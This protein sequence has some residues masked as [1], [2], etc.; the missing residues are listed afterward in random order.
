[1][2]YSRDFG[3]FA[4]SVQYVKPVVQFGQTRRMLDRYGEVQDRIVAD[5]MAETALGN[6]YSWRRNLVLSI[7]KRCCQ[8]VWIWQ[9]RNHTLDAAMVMYLN[10]ITEELLN[11]F[12]TYASLLERV[13]DGVEPTRAL[14]NLLG[15]QP[16]ISDAAGAQPQWRLTG[17]KLKCAI[18]PSP[19]AG[20][21]R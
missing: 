5:G 4:E 14:V 20:V 17:L 9:Y 19:M 15:E 21:L 7:V 13:Y 1:V 12:W 10:M 3:L 11:S 16:D 8:G 18:S 6:I 2:N